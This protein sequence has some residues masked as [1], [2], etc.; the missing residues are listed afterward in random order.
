MEN[1]NRGYFSGI[2]G[3]YKNKTLKSAV[4]IRFIEKQGD[5]LFYKSG[6]GITID[7]DINK[8]YQE[9]QDKIYV[10]FL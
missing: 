5:K 1:Y 9:L 6:G 10:P 8:E 4:M 7:S 2:F 3:I